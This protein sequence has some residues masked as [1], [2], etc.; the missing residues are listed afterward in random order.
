MPATFHS[1]KRAWKKTKLNRAEV[2]FIRKGD[3]FC[4]SPLRIQL[5]Y[6]VIL[7]LEGVLKGLVASQ[8]QGDL[9][10]WVWMAW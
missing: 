2:F 6:R 8:V 5:Y 4:F 7:S 3:I 1:G 10:R 9:S